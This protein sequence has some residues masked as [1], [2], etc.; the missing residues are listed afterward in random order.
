MALSKNENYKGPELDHFVT[1]SEPDAVGLRSIPL[2]IPVL[3]SY[4]DGSL[5]QY[6]WT[7]EMLADALNHLNEHGPLEDHLFLYVNPDIIKEGR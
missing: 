1:V 6:H 2:D 3:I 7:Q 4:P 5:A